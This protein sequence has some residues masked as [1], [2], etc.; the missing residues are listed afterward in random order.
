MPFVTG[1]RVRLILADDHTLLR[2]GMSVLLEQIDGVEV[3]AEAGDGVALIRLAEELEPD[4]VFTDIAMPGIDGV[5]AIRHLA[6]TRPRVRCVVVSMHETADMVRRA[7]EAGAAGYLLKNASMEEL[8][9]AI[10]EVLTRGAYFSP[11]V[12]P[13][14]LARTPPAATELLTERQLQILRLVALGHSSKEIGHALNL[15]PKTVD[16]HRGRIMHRLQVHDVAGL[17]RYALASGV[18][19]E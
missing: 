12:A 5:E 13:L 11:L 17:T 8:G 18:I 6:R 16:V 10:G 2:A 15:S 9:R 14:L 3:V 19:A 4:L 1:D 7:A